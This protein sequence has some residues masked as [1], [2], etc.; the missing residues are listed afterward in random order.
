MKKKRE[1]SFFP[2]GRQMRKPLYPIDRVAPY[3]GTSLI[4]KRTPLGPYR[5]RMPRVLGGW[6]FSYGEV[7]LY[8]IP[9]LG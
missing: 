5:R 9:K 3:R 2:R 7:P 1:V 8:G 4:R 6:A